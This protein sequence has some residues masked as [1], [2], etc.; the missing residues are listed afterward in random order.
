MPG[1]RE[2]AAQLVDHRRDPVQLRAR[3]SAG[4]RRSA[5]WRQRRSA[6]DTGRQPRR[7]RRRGRADAARGYSRGVPRRCRCCLPW[8]RSWP[9]RRRRHA[10]GRRPRPP[11]G[12][13]RRT[14]R[15]PAARR[16][17]APARGHHR[18]AHPV[19]DPAERHDRWSA[20]SVTNSS[21]ETLD[22]VNVLR[23]R[24]RRPDHHQRRAG[25]GRPATP[26]E[27][28]G[29]RIT[30]PGHLRHD[31][32]ARARRVQPYS[33][34]GPG[35][36]AAGSP[37]SRGCLLVRRARA[38]RPTPPAATPSP[39]AAPAPSSRCADDRPRRAGGH[40]PGGPVRAPGAR[41]TPTAASPTS[42]AGP[43]TLGDGRRAL[44]RSWRLRVRRRRPPVTWL[45]DPAVPDAAASSP[46]ATRP[47]RSAPEPATHR[48]GEDTARSRPTEPGRASGGADATRTSRSRR[49]A[50]T[51]RRG[52][53]LAGQAQPGRGRQAS[54]GLAVRRRRRR[55]RPPSATRLST[56]TR[57]SRVRHGARA[58]GVT[59]D[60]R[61]GRPA[62]R[63]LD[64]AAL[65]HRRPGHHGPGHRPA[66]IRG[67]APTRRDVA[68]HT[69]VF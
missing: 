49:P 5:R 60:A 26:E 57:A 43:S 33:T 42:T 32:R 65:A 36:G 35:R 23:V 9:H 56:R 51:G 64:A 68:G 53:P 50:R 19:L 46:P 18:H 37:T 2:P 48:S 1:G 31:R 58:S 12:S 62:E 28:V 25:R 16:A 7:G 41:T 30:D 21:D 17:D 6:S 44:R 34:A 55:P 45:V 29:D 52:S 8:W 54:P 4:P 27:P 40:R 47:R 10:G 14:R 66:V 38:R 15:R 11:A 22:G 3:P 20:A 61:H 63:Y 67:E 69:V 24:R 13:G 59:D 39:T